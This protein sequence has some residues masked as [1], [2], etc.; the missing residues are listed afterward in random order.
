MC[1]TDGWCERWRCRTRTVS[2]QV[3][4][5][6]SHEGKKGMILAGFVQCEVLFV[7]KAP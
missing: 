5:V 3:E 1:V 6:I 4:L 7:C 2:S